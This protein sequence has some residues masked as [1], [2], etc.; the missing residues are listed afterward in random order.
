MLTHATVAA[1]AAPG[2][3]L[4]LRVLVLDNGS[5]NVAAIRTQLD[6]EG[7][8]HT[9][10]DLTAAGRAPITAASLANGS[11]GFFQGVVMPSSAP[12]QMSADEL[13]ALH[14]YEQTFGVRQIDANEIPGPQVGMKGWDTSMFGGT[15]LDVKGTV[16]PA[17]LAAGWGYLDPS[18]SM[19]VTLPSGSWTGGIYA[20]LSSPLPAGDPL[21]AAGASFTPL[22]TIQPTGYPD[23]VFMGAYSVDGRDELVITGAVAATFL[24]FRTLAHGMVTWLTRGVH[25]G[26][27][28][29]YYSQQLDDVFGYDARW[30]AAN[31]CTPGE[32]C[33]DLTLTTPDIRM[34]AADVTALVA[35][36][37][38]HNYKPALV[39][40]GYN[41]L[42]NN[43]GEPWNGTDALTNAF[44]A[45]AGSL[46][47][48][49]H[50][51][52]HVYQGCL[53]NL[54]VR[55]WVCQTTDGLPVATDGSN[56]VWTPTSTVA[57]EIGTNIAR[58][59]AL[60]LAIDTAEYV[61]GEHSG[62]AQLPQ[63]PI[64]NPN[65]G[66]AL[67]QTGIGFIAADASRETAQRQV[68]SALTVPR[69]PVGVYYNV[70]TVADE[71]DEYNVLYN[72]SLAPNQFETY[73]VP[74]DVAWD[75]T[76]ILSND[77]RPYF[78]HASNLADDRLALTLMAAILS[79]YD[80]GFAGSGGFAANAPLVNQSLA[81]AGATLRN[82]QA[83]T[84]ARSQVTAYLQDGLVTVTNP[85]NAAAPITVPTGSTVVS[86]TAALD[87]YAGE[88]S[89]WA[90]GNSTISLVPVLPQTMAATFT[91]GTA[92]ST[93]I[94]AAGASTITV[95]GALPSGVT[96][97][98]DGTT[99]VTL[100]GTAALG[101]AAT[102]PLTV[103]ASNA[104]GSSIG[105]FTLT[106]ENATT[107]GGGGGGGDPTSPA[108]TTST[109]EPSET[110]TEPAVPPAITSTSTVTFTAGLAS[111]FTI[112]MTGTP[113][114]TLVSSALPDGLVL[115]A[116]VT[117]GTATISGTP[118]PYTGGVHPI[119]L[120]A[121]NAAGQATQ[122]LTLTVRAAPTFTTPAKATAYVGVRTTI[123]IQ[124]TGYPV[125]A[126]SRKGT[127]PKGL[128]WSATGGTATITG[129]PARGTSGT[130]PLTIT[131]KNNVATTK[132]AFTLTVLGAP[133]VTTAS[134]VT[135][136]ASRAFAVNVTT[137]GVPAPALR[138]TTTLPKGYRFVDAKN[139]SARIHGRLAPGRT[140]KVTIQA[141]NR[142]GSAVK[143]VTLR[144]R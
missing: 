103:T 139:G 70:S 53:Q 25:L 22:L 37:T 106:V 57:S 44:V 112:T 8:P 91:V 38:Q 15:L 34:T 74:V 137:S 127:L 86:G 129:T 69:H 118:A 89:T 82:Q 4:D 122:T 131:A 1:S 140:L 36:Q 63:Q 98:G 14:A 27:Y 141:S 100:S 76:Y 26:H 97:S 105:T 81:Q 111:S 123:T 51:Y 43:D 94:T 134:Y 45:N 109:P 77:P 52:E 95:A 56:L 107:G 101:T 32:D 99:A 85:T 135:V 61:S 11:E 138:T 124:A 130:Y 12:A 136:A 24:P 113:T 59:G 96:L 128:V 132:Q 18:I 90:T 58:A 42:Y 7:V 64:D 114:P 40:N 93:T 39:F 80:T 55:P 71:V 72:L 142:Y 9:D 54:A 78:A 121:T 84:A 5:G 46:R 104:N 31:N 88:L 144:T 10:V 87:P 20:L 110:S 2:Q 17:A 62:L 92:G 133:T 115:S 48:I 23:G 16:T 13:T 125:P 75:L 67:T 116:G 35:W 6:T 28:R 33:V 21:L 50:G 79:T 73:I 117:P 108:P 41:T 49:N 47:W 19:G 143:T 68:G 83:W 102:Y 29:N 126:L 120:T 3:R 60:G 66:P 119:T 30:D 65:F